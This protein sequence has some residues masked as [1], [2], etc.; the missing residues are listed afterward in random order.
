[1][2]AKNDI[3]TVPAE[4]KALAETKEAYIAPVIEIVEVCV[5]RGFQQSPQKL[6][7]PNRSRPSW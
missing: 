4:T 5:E 2:E 3:S 1:M 6:G 7:S